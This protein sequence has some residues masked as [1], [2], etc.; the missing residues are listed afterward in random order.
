[1]NTPRRDDGGIPRLRA[2]GPVGR[3]RTRA[4]EEEWGGANAAKAETLLRMKLQRRAHAGGLE[5]RHS[6]YGY[7]LIDTARKRVQDRSDM[8]LREV[9]AWLEHR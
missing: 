4:I 8:T 6:T 9:E 5:L 7:A 2:G 1:M 3:S